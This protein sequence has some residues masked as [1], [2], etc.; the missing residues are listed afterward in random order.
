MTGRAP[1]RV[2][3]HIRAGWLGPSN[4]TYR[5]EYLEIL[6][7]SADD[8]FPI[9]EG[10]TGFV[11]AGWLPDEGFLRRLY[12]DAVDHARRTSETVAYRQWLLELAAGFLNLASPK[13]GERQ[14]RLLDYGCGYGAL[15][16]MLSG[17]DVKGVGYEPS[18]SRIENAR[19]GNNVEILPDPGAVAQRGPF[20][21]IMCTEVLE[22]VADPR[23]TLRFLRDNAADDALLA[24]TVPNCSTAYVESSLKAAAAGAPLSMVFNPWEH[25]NYFSASSFRRMLSDEGFAVITDFGRTRGARAALDAIG[26][27]SLP[28]VVVNGLRVTKR[29]LSTT[30]STELFCRCV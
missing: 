17:R 9:V 27:P 21:L 18:A 25:L 13:A 1:T 15:L 30:P 28:T 24:F 5:P 26:Q 2:I 16:G 12:N 7:I 22:H 19:L 20:D 4:V 23:S 8:E 14:L 29:V 6:G 3:G 11:Y 10:P